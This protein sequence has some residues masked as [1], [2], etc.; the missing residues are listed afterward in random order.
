[1][2]NRETVVIEA[3]KNYRADILAKLIKGETISEKSFVFTSFRARL[4]ELRKI[5]LDS[6]IFIQWQ[7]A[8]FT[9]SHGHAGRFKK[10]YLLDLD[11]P[12]ALKLYDSINLD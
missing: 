6:G 10:Y 8:E 5:L 1:M 12:D 9:N 3:P 7:W 11:I 2:L 4:S